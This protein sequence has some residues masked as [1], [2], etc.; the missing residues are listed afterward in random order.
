[1]DFSPVL[2]KA[3]FVRRYEAG[4]FGNRSPTWNTLKEFLKTETHWKAPKT[5]VHI[6]N[7]IAGGRTWYNVSA[8]SVWYEVKR[9]VNRKEEREEN[10]YF[11]LMAP[12]ELTT[13]QGEIQQSTN[14]LDLY[15][16]HVK[17]PM[18]QSLIEGGRQVSGVTAVS[19]LKQFM[20]PTSYDWVEILLHRYP[21]HVIEFSC[22]SRYWGI[23]PGRNTIIWE[24]RGGY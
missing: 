12:T 9:I 22:Y 11:S 17:K 21:G 8:G 3:D 16:S 15:Y 20:D 5:L 19:L 18:R 1:M 24:V 23:L 4:E 13:F 6:R 14:Y 7:R 10:L 2:S